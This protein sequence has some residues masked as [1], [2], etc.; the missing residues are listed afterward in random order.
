MGDDPPAHEGSLII[1]NVSRSVIR[2]PQGGGGFFAYNFAAK[3]KVQLN[4]SHSYIGGT[5]EAVGGI[6]RPD[7]VHDS[8]VRI[9]SE[10]NLYRDEWADPCA[11]ALLGWNLGGG[12]GAPIAMQL[13]STVRNRLVLHS[14]ND[15][16]EG[17]T[18]GILATGGRAF[19]PAPRNQPPRNNYIELSLTGTT[20]FTPQCASVQATG[21][22]LESH[23]RPKPSLI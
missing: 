4:V 20:I 12:A 8:E 9:T 22:V 16:I 21:N 7:A 1:V 23:P 15:R 13:P 3:S 14:L 10:G 18:T 5:N 6:S 19:Y 2:S 17:F 11:S